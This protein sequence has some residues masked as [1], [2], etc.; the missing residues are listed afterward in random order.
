MSEGRRIGAHGRAEVGTH[1]ITDRARGKREDGAKEKYRGKRREN[2][3]QQKV[4]QER[5]EE[6]CKELVK[7]QVH[8]VWS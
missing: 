8:V 1:D 5:L 2:G 4:N 6:T 7:R 3:N